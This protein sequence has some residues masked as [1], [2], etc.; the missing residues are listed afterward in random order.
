M[1]SAQASTSAPSPA[2]AIDFLLLLQKLKVVGGPRMALQ[3]F[4]RA[5]MASIGEGA[6]QRPP[7]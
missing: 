6:R 3:R 5:C 4:A 2:A 7:I 1:A